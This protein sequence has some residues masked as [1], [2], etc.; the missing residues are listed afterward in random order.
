MRN[1]LFFI[2]NP[3]KDE[4]GKI[5]T[6]YSNVDI[7]NYRIIQGDSK[8]NYILNIRILEIICTPFDKICSRLSKS[9]N[10]AKKNIENLH[11]SKKTREKA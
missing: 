10:Y 11:V 5:L 3:K 8:F 4:C 1:F 2:S 6:H 7:Q 9:V